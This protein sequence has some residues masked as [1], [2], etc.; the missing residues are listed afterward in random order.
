MCVCVYVCCCELPAK[1][2]ESMRVPVNNSLVLVLPLLSD[3]FCTD[4]WWVPREVCG[5][6]DLVGCVVFCS[7]FVGHVLFLVCPCTGSR[8]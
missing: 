4:H 3:A 8:E 2:D 5:A 7:G 1:E 6:V